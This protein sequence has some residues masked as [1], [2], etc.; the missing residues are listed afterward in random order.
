MPV[1]GAGVTRVVVDKAAGVVRIRGPDADC[2]ARARAIMDFAVE[3]VP[4]T[5]EEIPWI[6]G[7]GGATIRKLR[8]DSRVI[9][10][11]LDQ[12]GG[13]PVGLCRAVVAV[14]VVAV[15]AVVLATVDALGMCDFLAIGPDPLLA[16]F[17]AVSPMLIIRRACLWRT[18][19]LAR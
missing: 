2:V 4:L 14:T 6:I 12:V 18:L 16:P 13:M 8:E 1:C 17:D 19:S 3:R 10:M 7:S 9:N 5:P 11:D 15:V